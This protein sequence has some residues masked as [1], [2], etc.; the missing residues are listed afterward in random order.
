MHIHRNTPGVL[1]AINAIFAEHRVNIEG[2]SLGTR[3][4]VGYVIT[5]IASDYT[6][7]MLAR[8]RPHGRD[9]PPAGPVRPGRAPR[10]QRAGPG[11]DQTIGVPG[12]GAENSRPPRAEPMSQ[13]SWADAKVGHTNAEPSGAQTQ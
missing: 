7:E 1:A 9:H 3:G 12:A 10:R 5:D 6:D 8:L 13:L 11:G 2:Q 4:D